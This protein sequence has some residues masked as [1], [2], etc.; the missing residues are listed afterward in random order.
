[1]CSI[2]VGEVQVISLLRKTVLHCLKMSDNITSIKFSPCGDYF[3]IANSRHTR[4]YEAPSVYKTFNPF[5]MKKIIQSSGTGDINSLWWSED[6]KLFMFAEGMNIRVCPMSKFSNFT[7]PRTL[8]GHSDL[9][10]ACFFGDANYQIIS[11]SR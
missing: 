7:L 9:L 3:A 4:V 6:S 1:L 5:V 2:A 10:V 11:I 8:S